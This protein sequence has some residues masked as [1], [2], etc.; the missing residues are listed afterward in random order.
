MQPRVETVAGRR[1][2]VGAAG[3]VAAL[4]RETVLR[5]GSIRDTARWMGSLIVIMRTSGSAMTGPMGGNAC[6]RLIRPVASLAMVMIDRCSMRL[7]SRRSCVV[8]VIASALNGAPRTTSPNSSGATPTMSSGGKP[9]WALNTPP[10][11]TSRVQDAKSR[12][13]IPVLAN[14]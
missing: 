4:I 9:R 12:Q 7:P 11:A 3:Q 10:N 5:C 6:S 13:F 8:S 1:R 14:R 2:D